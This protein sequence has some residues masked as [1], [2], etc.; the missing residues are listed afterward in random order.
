LTYSE[1][2][3]N[4]SSINDVKKFNS[5]TDIFEKMDELSIFDKENDNFYENNNDNDNEYYNDEENID[6]LEPVRDIKDKKLKRS[7][8]RNSL[9]QKVNH[10][11]LVFLSTVME[12]TGFDQ[13]KYFINFGSVK[14]NTR[15]RWSII[16]QCDIVKIINWHLTQEKTVLEKKFNKDGNEFIQNHTLDIDAFSVNYT[17]GKINPNK[18]KTIIL[19]FFPT[20]VGK[21]YK[22]IVIN[23]CKHKILF[24]IE[25]T[26]ISG[27]VVSFTN[28][29]TIHSIKQENSTGNSNKYL[30]LNDEPSFCES[31]FFCILI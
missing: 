14:I 9:K 22:K 21:Y 23:F 13:Q 28:D 8:K 4:N 2:H 17:H 20:A 15:K 25:G 26:G 5:T 11:T 18:E 29:T 27:K 16:L 19:S 12:Q 6:T 10:Q 31:N 7:L 24:N 3:I 1:N 30:L